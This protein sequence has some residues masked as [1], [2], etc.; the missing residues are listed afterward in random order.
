MWG[1][2][3]VPREVGRY[4]GVIKGEVEGVR[5]STW[6]GCGGHVVEVEVLGTGI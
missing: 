2:G 3:F 5:G 1:V 6:G 4:A